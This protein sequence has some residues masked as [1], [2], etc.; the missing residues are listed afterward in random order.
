MQVTFAVP[1]PGAVITQE[2]LNELRKR[3]VLPSDITAFHAI[4]SYAAAFG[5][6]LIV[7]Q[8]SQ[9][10]KRWSDTGKPTEYI[11]I[12]GFLDTS[13][14]ATWSDFT[15]TVV[16]ST[17][18]RFWQE[19]VAAKDPVFARIPRLV[20]F[21]VANPSGMNMWA[22]YNRVVGPR[23][24]NAVESPYPLAKLQDDP[25]G[26]NGKSWSWPQNHGLRFNPQSGLPEVFDYQ[27]YT[28][29][30]QITYSASVGGG[31]AIR[32][33]GMTD[34]SFLSATAGAIFGGGTPAERVAKIIGNL[35][36]K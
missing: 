24:V 36:V 29:A 9:A 22:D 32:V 8:D 5:G 12:N 6:L 26:F 20:K 30:Y 7:P 1:H 3:G 31:G 11:T 34:E 16:G 27:E 10:E 17:I 25:V 35:E 18:A 4:E 15:M 2:L 13:D 33:K 28:R 19:R 14:P 23:T 21:T